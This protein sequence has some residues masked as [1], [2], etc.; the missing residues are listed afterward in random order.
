MYLLRTVHSCIVD[1]YVAVAA[2]TAHTIV[3]GMVVEASVSYMFIAIY[4]HVTASCYSISLFN[5]M[6]AYIY[7]VDSLSLRVYACTHFAAMTSTT[8]ARSF[9]MLGCMAY[10]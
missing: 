7:T 6:S 10:G 8:T 4:L 1:D 2:T 9:A 5:I 3:R